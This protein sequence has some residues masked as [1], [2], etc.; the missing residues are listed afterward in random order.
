MKLRST[1]SVCLLI[2]F[3]T[4]AGCDTGPAPAAPTPTVTSAAAPTQTESTPDAVSTVGSDDDTE[5]ADGTTEATEALPTATGTIVDAAKI[6]EPT[7]PVVEVPTPTQVTGRNSG[8]AVTALEALAQLRDV[9]LAE[10]PDARLA[11][12]VNS[13]PGQQKILLGTSL[14]DP[15]VHAATPGG[16][17]R[18]WTLIAVSPSEERAV[19]FSTDGTVVDLTA[20]GQVPDELLAN[21][22]SPGAAAL[23]LS[24][25]DLDSLQDSEVTAQAAGERGAGDKF[26]IALLA[27]EAL[28][29]GPLPTPEAGGPSP[30]LVYQLFST[31]PATQLFVIFDAKTGDVVLDS[32]T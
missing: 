1:L 2:A 25:L 22:G 21:F 6:E 20:A 16:M 30:Q 23:D 28:G 14:G 19:A 32:G 5:P 26:G 18:N 17:G 10:M 3:L 9:A 7:E 12:L 8:H 29:I 13:L 31:D 24:A 4:L 11:M 15:N 27:P